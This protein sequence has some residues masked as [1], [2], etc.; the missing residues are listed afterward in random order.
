MFIIT[1]SFFEV[2]DIKYKYKCCSKKAI[3]YMKYMKA[4][5]VDLT[6]VRNN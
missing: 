4:V 1:D 6:V 3:E 5:D 2:N